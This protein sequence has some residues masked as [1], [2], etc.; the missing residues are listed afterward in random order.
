[1]IFLQNRSGSQQGLSG[2]NLGEFNIMKMIS[3]IAVA[4]GLVAAPAM[5]ATTFV[6]SWTVDQGPFWS[7]APNTYT[8]QQA[9]ALLFGGSASDY[10][11]ST[12]DDQ[13]ADI[14]HLA[15]VSTWGGDFNVCSGFPCG[16]KVAENWATSTGG[17]YASP[18]D[19]SAYV[20]DWAVG[21]QFRNY[22]FRITSAPEP[23]SWALMLGGFG[24]VGLALRDRRRSAVSFG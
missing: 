24:L 20:Q 12:I 1:M 5:A 11:I 10:A 2:T 3:L 9:A 21:P 17:L 7:P 16:T 19:Q 13:V 22:A 6:G 4:A 8:G 23:A 15:W 18:G 14:D